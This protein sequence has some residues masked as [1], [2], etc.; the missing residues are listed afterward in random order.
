V[1]VRLFG[2]NFGCFRDDFELSME[3]LDLG[4]DADRGCFEV[5]VESEDS[6]LRLLR[7]AAI[8]GAN[9]SGKS[10]IIRAA[11]A[12][13]SLVADSAV[14]S[15]RDR[16][17][18]QY[19][20][21]LLD[22]KTR[23]EPCQLGC[24]VVVNNRVVEYLIEFDKRTV[25]TE[26]IVERQASGDKTLLEREGR[27][28][29][30]GVQFAV[31]LRQI[32]RQN[33]AAISVAAQFEQEPFLAVFDAIQAS[34]A[35]A[36]MREQD[37]LAYTVQALDEDRQFRRWTLDRLLAPADLGVAAVDVERRPLAREERTLFDLNGVGLPDDAMMLRPVLTHRGAHGDYPIPFARESDGT[38][39]LLALS[40]PWYSL[41]RD[42]LTMFLDEPNSHLHPALFQSLLDVFNNEGAGGR[43]P[44]IVFSTHDVSLLEGSL[45]RDQTWFTEKDRDGAARL[46]SLAE[47]GERQSKHV[48]YRK[49]YMEGRY[50]AIPFAPNFSSL[51]DLPDQD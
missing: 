25:R 31:P 3:A 17:I 41:I 10:T 30:V 43:A 21:F 48:N 13:R 33:A 46:F 44:Q 35:P 1:L 32:T 28:I 11:E 4:S 6:P 26:R 49:R 51:F 15:Q 5:T 34:L 29:Q 38:R 19:E 22:P 24:E 40:G 20:P 39:N 9:A 2:R 7:V 14:G 50:G 16:P 37:M 18:D 27:D 36:D 42:Q 12:L 8:F 47:F 45:R 23:D